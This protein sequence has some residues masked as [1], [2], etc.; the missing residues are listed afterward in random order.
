[1]KSLRWF[2][3]A[4]VF[5]CASIPLGASAA[6]RKVV[7][8]IVPYA[9]G[10]NIDTMARLFSKRV[11]EILDET[12]VVDNHG[13]A[14]GI[15][16][17]GMVA[18]AAPDGSTLLFN[19]EV[20][21]MVPLFVK[22]VPYDPIKDFQ[23]IARLARSPLV[24]VVTPTVKANNLAE[25]VAD[26]KARPSDYSFAISGAGT[27]P[28]I[29]AESFKYRTGTKAIIVNYRGTGPA[30]LDVAGGH[31]NLMMVAPPAAMQMVRTGK[32]K[33]LAVTS[34]QR[35]AGAPGVPSA[36]ESGLPGF[37]VATSFGFWGPKGL[38][39]DMLTR[40]TNAM[41]AAAEDPALIAAANELGVDT[42]WESPE[43]FAKNL[44]AEFQQNQAILEKAGVKPE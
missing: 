18:R 35:F 39:K 38:P 24:F 36:A 26:M 9:A 11:G 40:L 15:I 5:V 14:N 29:G 3:A 12:W 30:I 23:P 4:A 27:S 31:T 32:L 7:K 41:R 28:N 44:Q 37:E 6:D 22:K 13:G 2:A 21:A 19:G 25:L 43:L 10:G 33:A 17:A 20:H 1:M 42:M 8:V 34:D 16:G